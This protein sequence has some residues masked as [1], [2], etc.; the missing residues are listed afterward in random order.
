MS[1]K[2]E[3]IGEVSF[4]VQGE[5]ITDRFRDF[6]LEGRWTFA[7][8]ELVLCMHGMTHE[9]AIEILSGEKTLSGWDDEIELIDDVNSEEYIKQLNY[10][11]HGILDHTDGHYY[12]PSYQITSF[13]TEDYPKD[14]TGG[15]EP[16]DNF[17]KESLIYYRAIHY[18]RDSTD[19]YFYIDEKPMFFSRVDTPPM[20]IETF[21]EPKGAFINHNKNSKYLNEDGWKERYYDCE[22]DETFVSDTENNFKWV[23]KSPDE[24]KEEIKEEFEASKEKSYQNL[25]LVY[26]SRIIKQADE[27]DGFIELTVGSGLYLKE[28]EEDTFTT[29]KIPKAPFY[30]WGRS[31]MI[32]RSIIPDLEWSNVC[33]Q[34]LKMGGDNPN[35]TDWMLGAGLNLDRSYGFEGSIEQRIMVKAHNYFWDISDNARDEHVNILVKSS[36]GIIS[37]RVYKPKANEYDV[38]EGCIIVIPFASPE[39]QIAAERACKGRGAVITEVGGKLCHLAT[40]GRELKLNLVLHPD[41]MSLLNEGD[42]V[43]INMNDGEMRIIGDKVL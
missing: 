19:L 23:D 7:L 36:L 6:V 37:G 11:Y 41:A 22:E 32:D 10:M 26:E 15:Y 38:P 31:S 21:R 24:I 4:S 20:W 16:S 5:F 25:L 40:V 28:G 39:Y 43:T 30:K 17:D 33:P 9:I 29:V 12:R 8:K 3:L 27:G 34:G 14:E 35:H 18:K 42:Y 1:A 2:K 13:G